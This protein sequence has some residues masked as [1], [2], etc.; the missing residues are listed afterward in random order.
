M[1][2]LLPYLLTGL[3]ALGAMELTLF[4]HTERELSIVTSP[5]T[6]DPRR[7]VRLSNI[8]LQYQGHR[9]TA[10]AKQPTF[11]YRRL[12]SQQDG[13]GTKEETTRFF[14]GCKAIQNLEIIRSVGDGKHKIVYEVKLPWGEHAVAKRCK[15]RLCVSQQ[16]LEREA[17]YLKELQSQYDKKTIQVLGEC[18]RKMRQK[19]EGHLEDFVADFS[20][21]YTSLIE[22]GKP[23]IQTWLPEEFHID[24]GDK[25]ATI[26]HEK[27]RECFAEYFTPADHGDFITIAQQYA[28]YS[29]YPLIMRPLDDYKN[30]DTDNVYAEQYI[31]TK[32]GIRHGDIDMVHSCKECSYEE[33]LEI[34][35]GIVQTVTNSNFSC[36]STE[37][38]EIPVTVSLSNTRIN[39]TEASDSCLERIR[40]R[41]IRRAIEDRKA[42]RKREKKRRK[43]LAAKIAAAKK[44][45]EEKKKKERRDKRSLDRSKRRHDVQTNR[46]CVQFKNGKQ[47]CRPVSTT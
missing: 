16:R 31:L 1:T 44:A 20:V 33:A 47:F 43:K 22:I 39:V 38:L 9:H 29:K 28:N 35:C 37:G 7:S 2:R 15:T 34:N 17:N 36:T 3:A 24:T 30:K 23:L 13:N 18:K 12:K 11:S 32:A 19:E 14:L 40:D 10:S 5:E 41:A 27:Y 26:P 8:N 25:E 46:K 4:A 42:K 45:A 6:N 21:G